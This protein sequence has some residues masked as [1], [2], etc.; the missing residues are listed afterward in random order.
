MSSLS[1]VCAQTKKLVVDS[2]SMGYFWTGNV[3]INVGEDKD[4]NNASVSGPATLIIDW[5]L[6]NAGLPGLDVGQLCTELVML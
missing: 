2:F 3:L 5:E 6:V 4:D 1:G